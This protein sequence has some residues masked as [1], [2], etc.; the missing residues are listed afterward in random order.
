M[1]YGII[2]SISIALAIEL[3]SPSLVHAQ[4]QPVPASPTTA[5]PLQ[6]WEYASLRARPKSKVL[7][8]TMAQPT[9]RSVCRINSIESDRLVCKDWFGK[10]RIYKP[11]EVAALVVR[12]DGGLQTRLWIGFNAASGFAAWGTYVLAP[13]CIPCAAATAFAAFA[14]LTFAGAV[15]YCDDQPDSLVYL[16]PNLQIEYSKNGRTIRLKNLPSHG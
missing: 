2:R 9:R 1:A 3:L 15:A 10:D 12:G 14:F 4:G 13:I 5:D 6:N 7:V 8:I 11:R 16:A